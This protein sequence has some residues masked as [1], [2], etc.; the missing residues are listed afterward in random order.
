MVAGGVSV[1]S[2]F[3]YWRGSPLQRDAAVIRNSSISTNEAGYAVITVS[4]HSAGLFSKGA[5]KLQYCTAP[6][7]GRRCSER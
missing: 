6:P 4:Q 3:G 7:N 2:Q 5:G 1:A